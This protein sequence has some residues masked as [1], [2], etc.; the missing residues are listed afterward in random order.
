MVCSKCNKEITRTD[1]NYCPE[2][3][4]RL[5]NKNKKFIISLSI[6]VVIIFSA[7][8]GMVM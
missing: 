3:G 4:A 1:T 8:M 7:I 2:C 5:K 6:I